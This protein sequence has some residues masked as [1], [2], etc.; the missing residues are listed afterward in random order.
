MLRG[1][2]VRG[3]AIRRGPNGTLRDGGLREQDLRVADVS[4]GESAL[5]V[6]EVVV[7]HPDKRLVEPERA[8]AV[9]PREERTAPGRERLR[10]MQA[11]LV[12][13][14]DLEP[15][16]ARERAPNLRQRRELAS[17]EDVPLDEVRLPPVAREAVLVHPDRLEHHRAARLQETIHRAEVVVVVVEPDRLEH[18]D[19]H[20]LVEAAGQAAVVLEQ[21]G[22]AVAEPLARDALPDVLVLGAAD[23][24]RGHAA[25]VARRRVDRERAPAR[26]DLEESVAGREL[27]G[28][29]DAVELRQLRL[30]E[31][32]SGRLEDGAGIGQRRVEKERVE[33]GAEIVVVP[34]VLAAARD[35]VAVAA[36]A[37]SLDQAGEEGGRAAPAVEQV[38]VAGGEP[39][40]GGQIRRRPE[41][42]GVGLAERDVT[43]QHEAPEGALVAHGDHGVEA[44]AGLAELADLA[45]GQADLEA[46]PAEAV[47]PPQQQLARH[48]RDRTRAVRAL[49]GAPRRARLRPRWKASHRGVEAFTL[50]AT[51]GRREAKT[52]PH[53]HALPRERLGGLE[54]AQRL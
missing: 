48:G 39:G 9:E 52:R 43:P 25:P 31:R 34:D 30:L 19:R 23:R 35:G 24:G 11:D 1:G 45:R 50:R 18:L 53:R 10:V 44:R 40:D 8:H 42:L 15:G 28:P 20:R 29:G 26:A 51:A 6:R 54:S 7:P 33:V 49:R 21:Q 3:G 13:V 32:D 12:D 36:V 14:R 17:R 27:E 46:T 16:R 38:D 4:L 47:E 22:D 41:A 37:D 5:A 2:M